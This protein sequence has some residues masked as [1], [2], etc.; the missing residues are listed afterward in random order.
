MSVTIW[1]PALTLIVVG[2]LLLLGFAVAIL[3]ITA[4]RLASPAL[5]PASR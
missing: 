1:G 2:V 4:R 3:G 5:P